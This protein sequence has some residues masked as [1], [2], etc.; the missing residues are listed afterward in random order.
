MLTYLCSH[1]NIPL[2]PL[3]T[4]RPGWLRPIVRMLSMFCAP[5]NNGPVRSQLESTRIS[6]LVCVLILMAL[7]KQEG[8]LSE[9]E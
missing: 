4:A 7:S 2:V 9:A 5:H 1:A 6:A 3:P 8:F